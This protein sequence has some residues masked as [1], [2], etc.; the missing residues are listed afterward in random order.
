M[1]LFFKSFIIS[2]LDSQPLKK[3]KYQTNKQMALLLELTVFL[4][5]DNSDMQSNISN[6]YLAHRNYWFHKHSVQIEFPISK[7]L[8]KANDA[9]YV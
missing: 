6:V 7:F 1:V 2:K 4:F 8:C 5:S 3:G 9:P